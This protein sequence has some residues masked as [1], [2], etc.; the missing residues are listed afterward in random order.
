MTDFGSAQFWRGPFPLYYISIAHL[1]AMAICIPTLLSQE[2][3]NGWRT[4][5][6]TKAIELVAV[7][8]SPTMTTFVLKN[9]SAKPITAFSVSLADGTGHT[10]DY[11]AAERAMPAGAAYELRTGNAEATRGNHILRLSA[12]VFSD[13]TSDGLVAE[14]QSIQANRLGHIVETERV[15]EILERVPVHPGPRDVEL[16]VERVGER[17]SSPAEALASA[18]DVRLPGADIY[19]LDRSNKG[20]MNAF[21]S[22]VDVSRQMAIWR[23]NQLKAAAAAVPGTAQP[24]PEQ[25]LA[26]ALG[27]YRSLHAKH[28][29]FLRESRGGTLQ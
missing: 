13:G 19:A 1:M 14:V 23:I 17:P 26:E 10:I 7:Q 16:L 9:V 18:R 15:R 27:F 8:Q 11:F 3:L 2:P 28:Q 22:G 29:V 12:V 4:D 25:I 24:S 21:C 20:A 6:K 5:P